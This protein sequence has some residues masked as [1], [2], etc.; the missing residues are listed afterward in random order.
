MNLHWHQWEDDCFLLLVVKMFFSKDQL[1]FKHPFWINY[2]RM[3]PF[4]MLWKCAH[5]LVNSLHI[6]QNN[7]FLW[8]GILFTLLSIVFMFLDVYSSCFLFSPLSLT[9]T[10]INLLRQSKQMHESVWKMGK[11]KTWRWPGHFVCQKCAHYQFCKRPYLHFAL[12][13]LYKMS[14]L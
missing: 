3:L 4:I 12:Y 6:T 1:T 10:W 2:S 5:Y 14:T 7:H 8:T 9:N 13:K 11:L